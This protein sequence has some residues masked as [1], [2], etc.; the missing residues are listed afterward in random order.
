MKLL[1]FGC[2]GFLG[3]RLLPML[4][5]AGHDVIAPHSR[6]FDL[7]KP[8]ANLA[9]LGKPDVVVHAAAV[10]GGLPY[11]IENQADI[12]TQNMKMNIHAFEVAAALKVKQIVTVG[13]ACSYPG[14]AATDLSEADLFTGPLHPT[15]ECHGFT[16]LAMIAGNRAYFA[17]HS[18]SGI[19]LLPANLYGPGDVF[20]ER[21]AH[22][23]AALIKKF[24]DAVA[25]GSDVQ[26][27]GDGTPIREFM[28]IDD[29][30]LAILRACE[31]KVNGVELINVGTGIGMSIRALA[32]LLA[33]LTG[34]SGNI[35]WA[36]SS[37][38]GAMRKVM[39]VDRMRTILGIDAPTDLCDG[40]VRTLDWYLP[41][42]TT[43]DA[44]T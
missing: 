42:K 11:D 19:H 16:K 37:S 30:A 26:L 29:L 1:L 36:G 33:E 2:N 12:F 44:R 20:Q 17:S 22:V 27:L 10:Y 34:F 5:R 7:T 39:R 40:L 41:Q 15:V 4:V 23:V 6:E 25:A 31:V 21:R 14:D 13:S 3:S 18:L 38:N 43:A 32:E 35:H 9:A 8:P 28:Y 24:T